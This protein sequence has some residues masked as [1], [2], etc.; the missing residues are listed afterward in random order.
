MVAA[1]ALFYAASA[2]QYHGYAWADQTCAGMQVFCDS[3]HY[4][5]IT[6]VAVIAILFIVHAHAEIVLICLRFMPQI[7]FEGP[8]L[9]AGRARMAV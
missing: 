5:G 7:P 8:Y 1:T 2:F 3:P 4:V 6:A 9:F